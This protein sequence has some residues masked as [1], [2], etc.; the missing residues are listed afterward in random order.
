[1][2]LHGDL[3]DF[4]ALQLVHLVEAA[5]L[6]TLRIKLVCKALRSAVNEY[7]DDLL[8]PRE[9]C[10]K[11][12]AKIQAAAKIHFGYVLTLDEREEND[13]A[14]FAYEYEQEWG[15]ECINGLLLLPPAG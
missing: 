9:L 10:M 2:M 6:P 12:A 13:D 3:F 1:M 7:M 14:I 11:A 8:Q 15:P 4:R 5:W